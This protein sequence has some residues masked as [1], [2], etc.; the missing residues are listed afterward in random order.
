[1]KDGM[2][3]RDTDALWAYTET[4][5][6][7]LQFCIPC[8]Y[9]LIVKSPITLDGEKLDP[10]CHKN[11]RP[12]QCIRHQNN[13]KN[14]AADA[15]DNGVKVTQTT[16]K[17]YEP[18]LR[19]LV[20]GDGDFSFSLSLANLLGPDACMQCTS[21]L[22]IEEVKNT[23]PD[24]NDNIRKLESFQNVAV[25]GGVDATNLEAVFNPQDIVFDRIIFNFP[26]VN[27]VVGQDGQYEQL[28][29]NKTLIKN[30]IA[31][32]ARVLDQK[33]SSQIQL[34]HKTKEPFSW[35]NIPN[36][37]PEDSGVAFLRSIIFDACLFPG[38]TPRKAGENKSFPT[39]DAVVHCFQISTGTDE[40]VE[41]IRVESTESMTSLLHQDTLEKFDLV[42]ISRARLLQVVSLLQLL[43]AKGAPNPPSKKRPDSNK[44]D[45]QNKRRNAKP[46]K[47]GRFQ[48]RARRK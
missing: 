14:T 42:K 40:T 37:C 17:F 16:P 43:Y 24:A 10:P 48:K 6:C 33:S 39:F 41:A 8:M 26:C 36:L 45:K 20:V 5:K 4:A 47:Q 15:D 27:D 32:A 21:F 12:E 38:Y 2:E 29:L 7:A 13:L 34:T 3:M 30:F 25:L 11:V 46:K 44:M 19:Y 23:Y 18:S 35:W 22:S 1:M 31:S 28:E 9:K